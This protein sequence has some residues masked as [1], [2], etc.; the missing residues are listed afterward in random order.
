METISHP[1]FSLK[2]LE[3]GRTTLFCVVRTNQLAKSE[4]TKGRQNVAICFLH[5]IQLSYNVLNNR[6]LLIFIEAKE[7]RNKDQVEMDIEEEEPKKKKKVGVKC[8]H[9]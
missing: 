3:F 5:R 2:F 6:G 7:A 4:F 9:K 8:F 1:I